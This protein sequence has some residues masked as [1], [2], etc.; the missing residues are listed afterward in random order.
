MPKGLI[1]RIGEVERYAAA[2]EAYSIAL[3]LALPKYG[4]EQHRALDV[5]MEALHALTGDAQA[6]ENVDDMH[7]TLWH[8]K[9]NDESGAIMRRIAEAVEQAAKG[10]REA[11]H[12]EQRRMIAA[13]L[14]SHLTMAVSRDFAPLQSKWSLFDD[15]LRRHVTGE[16]KPLT[17]TGVVVDLL[18][19][20]R[21][22]LKDGDTRA[23]VV[24]RVNTA[25]KIPTTTTNPTTY[26]AHEEK[27]IEAKEIRVRETPPSKPPP[28]TPA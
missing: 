5:I 16:P 26:L 17:M 19:A 4:P 1:E 27:Q 18:M 2:M 22:G 9:V 20:A 24:K 6:Q 7:Q 12:E 14:H 21:I 25:L 8:A 10:Y 11:E 13:M 3:D 23:D 28:G 15:L